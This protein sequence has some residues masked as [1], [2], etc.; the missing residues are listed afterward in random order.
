MNDLVELKDLSKDFSVLY[1][2]DEESIRTSLEQYLKKLFTHVDAAED[3]LKGLSLYKERK[4]DLVITDIRMPNLDG[5]GML[6]KI[7][8][9]NPEQEMIV[10]SAYTDPAYFTEAIRLGVTG[11]I[12]KPVNYM[13]MNET[14]YRSLSKLHMIRE[15]RAY[16]EN[17]E[18]LVETR[19]REKSKLKEEKYE[20]FEKTLQS[21]VKITEIEQERLADFYKDQITPAYN[22][23]YL[24]FILSSNYFSHKYS[25]INIVDL[26]H[27]TRYNETNGSSEG[28]KLLK[29]VADYFLETY[30]Q[31]KLFR[32]HG[33]DFVLISPSHVEI[34]LE[35]LEKEPWFA[36]TGVT[37]QNRHID[38]KQQEVYDLKTL[39]VLL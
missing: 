25:C 19:I 2:E 18:G 8:E 32:I 36:E 4:Y 34:D 13:Q 12:I 15:N 14:L 5:I 24:N 39:E 23:E 10:V 26:Q 22:P 6:S 9:I 28:D 27:F 17:L 35:S 30:T 3:G 16:R 37:L 33:D 21:L 31:S 20:N 1:A 7:K 11:Y 29:R 38:F